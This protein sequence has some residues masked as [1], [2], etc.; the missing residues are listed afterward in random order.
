MVSRGESKTLWGTA[1]DSNKLQECSQG[2][3]ETSLDLYLGFT[4]VM[5]FELKDVCNFLL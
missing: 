4:Y 3:K 2:S 5:R 1:V